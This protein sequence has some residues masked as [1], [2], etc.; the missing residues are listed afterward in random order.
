MNDDE[1]ENIEFCLPSNDLIEPF[2]HLNNEKKTKV[3][4]LGL[5]C[6]TQTN[7]KIHYWNHKEME[8]EKNRII[9]EKDKEKGKVEDI[10]QQTQELLNNKDKINSEDRLKL[11]ENIKKEEEMKFKKIVDEKIEAIQQV[12]KSKDEL[13]KKM[14][15][16]RFTMDEKVNIREEKLK[17]EFTKREESLTNEI[18]TLRNKVESQLKTTG[19]SY[20]AGVE[21]EEELWF[22]LNTFYPNYRIEDNNF[23]H[24]KEEKRKITHRGDFVIYD[25]N[26]TVLIES[27]NYSGNIQKSKQEAFHNDM[28]NEKNQDL[29]CGIFISLKTGIV[30]KEDMSWE[31][32]GGKPVMWLHNTCEYYGKIKFAY[33]FLKILVN[34]Q[35]QIDFTN[36]EICSTMNSK[37]SLLKG[38]LNLQR[39]SLNNYL[40]EQNKLLDEQEEILFSEY[41]CDLFKFKK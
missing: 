22:K 2:F 31:L 32:I 40:S 27:K 19:N 7:D 41:I 35:N 10:L 23:D 13:Y 18:K 30:G 4:E 8:D 20:Y 36:E 16:I 3:I 24:E 21:G 33:N 5:M 28:K 17:D 1:E 26:F 25:K 12:E 38:K 37:L 29:D 9:K 15:E 34:S 6:F 39:R 14:D 11:I